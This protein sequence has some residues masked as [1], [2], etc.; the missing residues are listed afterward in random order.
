MGH[1]IA[2]VAAMAGLEAILFDTSDTAL[3]R[4]LE[5]IAS[6]LDGAVQRGKLTREA[7]HKARNLVAGD[8]NLEHA[9]AGADLVI[10]AIVE[11]MDA[12]RALLEQAGRLAP[13]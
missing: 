10:E 4:A 13:G 9:V 11:R 7:A 6:N 2:Q 8:D 1:G 5:R 12:K 3:E